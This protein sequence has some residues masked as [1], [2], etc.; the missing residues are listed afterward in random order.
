MPA[1]FWLPPAA[2]SRW[3]FSMWRVS[4]QAHLHLLDQAIL[5]QVLMLLMFSSSWNGSNGMLTQPD[6]APRRIRLKHN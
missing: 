4:L 6:G 5:A 3:P 1:E 2:I